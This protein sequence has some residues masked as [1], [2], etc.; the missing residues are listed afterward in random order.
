MTVVVFL[1]AVFLA[2]SC[3]R[4]NAVK[5]LLSP[6]DCC[7]FSHCGALGICPVVGPIAVK[8]MLKNLV[9]VVDFLIAVFL[10]GSWK[11]LRGRAICSE[12]H[13]KPS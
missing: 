11:G 9:N 4:A 12:V 8:C 7:I 6:C 10:E 3:S 13:V 2:V 1:I 5:I